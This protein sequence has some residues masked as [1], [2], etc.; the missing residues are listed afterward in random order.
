MDIITAIKSGKRYKRK[1][2]RWFYTLEDV[3]S[4]DILA[5][6]WEV[7]GEEKEEIKLPR[8]VIKGETLT[9]EASFLVMVINEQLIPA[10]ERYLKERK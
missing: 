8:I 3:D 2:D 6:D 5:D 1:A 4:E 9:Y 10:I 7:E